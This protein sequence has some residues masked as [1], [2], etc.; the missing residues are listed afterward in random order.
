MPNSCAAL[1]PKM[2]VC[3]PEAGNPLEDSPTPISTMLNC[4]NVLIC[5]PVLLI[6]GTEIQ[7]LNL[8]KVLLSVGYNVTI[9]C[10][11]EYD[12]TMVSAF[13]STG[14]GVI[15]M[16]L[17]RLD[18]FLHLF[19]KLRLI[20]IK[21]R[22]AVVHV[23]Y[24]APGL[25]PIIAARLS[26]LRTVFGTVHQPSRVYGMKAKLLLRLGALL[27][28]A[29]FCVS[30]SAEESWFGNSELFDPRHINRRRKHF[31]IYNAV[32]VPAVTQ[33]V[34]STDREHL[35]ESLG[36]KGRPVIGV[37]G[38]LRSEKG[39]SVLLNAMTDVIE[40][41]P[42]VMLLIV[43][44]GPDREL[45]EKRTELWGIAENVIWMGSKEP[46]EVFELYAVMDVVAV[47]SLFEGFGLAAA[48]AMAA[49]RPVVASDV[50]GLRE[51]VEDGV[52]GCLVPAG[53]S[54][55][56]AE[57][58]MDLLSNASKAQAMGEAGRKRIEQ[59]FS[60]ERFSESILAAYHYFLKC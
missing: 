50:D 14:A 37:V 20:L 19:R 27:C 17:K 7:T 38:R 32:D 34:D 54:R 55:A 15:L 31:T 46:S 47:P 51:V 58:L 40:A 9:L 3:P 41:I 28:T 13:R 42:D 52:S 45:L 22:P 10:Y 39:H 60:I 12:D 11:Y 8:T 44:N 48:E 5:T 33:V 53:D 2:F 56:M 57:G 43:G 23:Q 18:G 59:N 29:F 21:L 36:L 6:G 26:G 25:I 24:I 4:Q 16:G 30:T 49:R 35:R 1:R